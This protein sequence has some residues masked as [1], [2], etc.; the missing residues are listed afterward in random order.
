MGLLACE[1]VIME[2][3]K[4]F[5]S[6]FISTRDKRDSLTV[7][8]DHNTIESQSWL[9]RFTNTLNSCHRKL[10]CKKFACKPAS[11]QPFSSEREKGVEIYLHTL[12]YSHG[13]ILSSPILLTY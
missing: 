12:L 10:G 11:R 13:N 6:S 9:S 5:D 7:V 3:K 1:C 4:P 2:W 8:W